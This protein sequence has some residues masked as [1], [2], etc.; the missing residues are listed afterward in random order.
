MVIDYTLIYNNKPL[1]GFHLSFRLGH[2]MD[3]EKTAFFIEV[4]NK[5]KIFLPRINRL[6]LISG[7]KSNLFSMKFFDQFN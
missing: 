2:V 4:L 3:D 6:N 5:E 7:N 1:F